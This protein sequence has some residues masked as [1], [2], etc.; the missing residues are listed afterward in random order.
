MNNGNQVDDSNIKD[1]AIKYLTE[2]VGLTNEQIYQLQQKL[3]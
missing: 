2:R 3:K 1:V